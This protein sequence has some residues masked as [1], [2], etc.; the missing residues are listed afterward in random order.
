MPFFASIP[1][2]GS[3][4]LDVRNQLCVSNMYLKATSNISLVILVILS[5]I[6]ASYETLK[7]LT[8]ILQK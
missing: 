3:Q 6:F 1:V 5:D 7:L 4:N 8:K 2:A